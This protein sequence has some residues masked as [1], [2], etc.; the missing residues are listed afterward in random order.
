MKYIK[1]SLKIIGLSLLAIVVLVALVV[2]VFV[3]TSPEFGAA[4]SEA[5]KKEYAK[6][7]HYKDELFVNQIASE[8]DVDYIKGIQEMMTDDPSRQPVR[9]IEV[10]KLD[11]F[12]VLSYA[13][14]PRLTWFGHSA[15]LLE[16]K[17]YNILLDPMLGETPAPH[18]WL[19]QKRYSKELPIEIEE[20]PFID[21][22][23]FS[24]DH[25]DHL[26]YTT[27][28]KIKHK[29]GMFFVPL[30]VG[31]H[32][33][34]WGVDVDKVVE[35]DWWQEA[36]FEDMTFVCTPSRHFSGRGLFDRSTT[37]W[38]SWVLKSDTCAVYFSGDSGFGPHFKEIGDK[39]GPFDIGLMECGQYNEQWHAIHMMPEETVQAGIDI[40][41]KRIVPIHWA[42]FTLSLHSWTDP[43]E[44]VMKEANRLS[45]P[46]TSP[47][48]GERFTL[49]GAGA[50][51]KPWWE[52]YK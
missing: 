29:V 15:F 42:A 35:L 22:V 16:I 23:V 30:G 26:D 47:Q 27:I 44:R 25:Y 8:M 20:L 7:N 34:A 38:A 45:V 40:R 19:G 18:P 14:V 33:R 46:L 24:H 51:T 9:S 52:A 39:Y 31:N 28:Q 1:L 2:S 43:I 12:D 32:L 5:Q 50:T 13:A 6:T 36:T 49:D 10:V 41:A 48:I 17:K 37:L 11:S 21:A 4:P 3:N